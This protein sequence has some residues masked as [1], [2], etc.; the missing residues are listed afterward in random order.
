MSIDYKKVCIV[1]SEF[2]SDLSDDFLANCTSYLQE[3]GIKTIKVVTVPGCFEIPFTI[4]K[5]FKD[6]Y[7]DAYIA[8]GI[9]IKGETN[10]YEYISNAVS[11]AI[12]DLNLNL[13]VPVIF[14]VLTCENREQVKKR[15]SKNDLNKGKEFAS[16]TIKMLD[17][18]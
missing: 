4:N 17:I 18:K 12:M 5:I 11:N 14:G 9:L 6:K 7:F 16:T 13:S 15:V 10:H 3:K 8:L 1:V 2:Y